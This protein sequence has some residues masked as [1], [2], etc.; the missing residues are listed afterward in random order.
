MK[1]KIR[2]SV[3]LFLFICRNATGSSGTNQ[4]PFNWFCAA[5]WDQQIQHRLWTFN[6]G[7]RYNLSETDHSS[8][9]VGP[10]LSAGGGMPSDGY[11]TG[12]L[13]SG[14]LQAWVDHNLGM[15]ALADAPKNTGAY[16]GV[17]FGGSYIGADGESIDDENGISFGP[18][19]RAGFRFGVT[20][21][22]IGVGLYYKQG[23]EKGKWRRFEFHVLV[24]L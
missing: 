17:G 4:H 5:I 7:F 11:G 9:N 1:P 19:A 21:T 24:D 12:F 16:F 15:G 13:H 18:M 2:I 23:L 14:D 8:F 3:C 22:S 20:D 6:Y 10:L